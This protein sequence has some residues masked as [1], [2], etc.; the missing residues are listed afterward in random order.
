MKTIIM[1]VIYKHN[2]L[3]NEE[4]GKASR[5]DETGQL[6]NSGNESEE[7]IDTSPKE[8]KDEKISSN[9][10]ESNVSD[11]S[12]S[13]KISFLSS[14]V[15]KGELL[16]DF[17]HL[18]NFD[19]EDDF[20]QSQNSYSIIESVICKDEDTLSKYSD[21]SIASDSRVSQIKDGN[22]IEPKRDIYEEDIVIQKIIYYI[23]L[24]SDD[25]KKYLSQQRSKETLIQKEE[26]K[27][28][29]VDNFELELDD[30]SDE[31]LSMILNMLDNFGMF[32]L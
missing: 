4:D 16:Q 1:K 10:E 14:I 18:S 29:T 5:N 30:L 26:Y 17:D 9:L 28:S 12:L 6:N 8:H 15:S 20:L 25:I 2:S 3:E 32:K 31:L 19:P 22:I 7:I 27:E 21:F 13:N 23:S 11:F 24:F